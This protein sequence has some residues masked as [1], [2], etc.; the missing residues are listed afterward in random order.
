MLLGDQEIGR[1]FLNNMK[2]V[3]TK[4]HKQDT[5]PCQYART[6]YPTSYK[7]PRCWNNISNIVHEYLF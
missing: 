5:E 3:K 1:G 4:P 6:S 2:R 7:M